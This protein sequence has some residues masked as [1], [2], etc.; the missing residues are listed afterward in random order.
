[1]QTGT[2]WPTPSPSATA[3]PRLFPGIIISPVIF[4]G[5][6][7]SDVS[8]GYDRGPFEPDACFFRRLLKLEKVVLRES[9]RPKRHLDLVQ[10]R[11]RVLVLC[12][13]LD[14]R[15]RADIVEAHRLDRRAKALV[16]KE[17]SQSLGR[18]VA[19]FFQSRA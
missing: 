17:R 13:G 5:M 8:E 4:A 3:V 18:D 9:A 16:P 15:F 12:P 7:C 2:S 14:W 6:P 19:L 1:M 11:A 10:D